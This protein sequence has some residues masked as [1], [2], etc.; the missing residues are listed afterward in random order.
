VLQIMTNYIVIVYCRHCNLFSSLLTWTS[1]ASFHY[2]FTSSMTSQ[3]WLETVSFWAVL[4]EDT[5]SLSCTQ[6]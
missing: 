2:A 4:S 6:T 1:E 3:K 5:Y